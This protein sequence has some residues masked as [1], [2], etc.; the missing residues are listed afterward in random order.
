M[1]NTV[2]LGLLALTLAACVTVGRE[3]TQDQLRGFEK[4]KTTISQVVVK[5]GNPDSSTVTLDGKRTISYAFI[6]SQ[7]RP[8]SFIPIFGAFVGGSDVRHS[9]ASLIF[10][11]DGLLEN[12][13]QSEG[14][15][16][17]GFGL[18]AGEYRTPDRSLPQEAK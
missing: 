18:S 4:G 2:A 11:K 17:A 9:V 10:D 16:G 7:V 15:T 6:H 1:R 14:A 8:E 12:Y 5:L 13:Y 3:V